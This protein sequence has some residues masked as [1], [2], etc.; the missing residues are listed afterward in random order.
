MSDDCGGRVFLGGWVGVD[1]PAVIHRA[2]SRH[3]LCTYEVNG[4]L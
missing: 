4:E 3:K 2:P 1:T